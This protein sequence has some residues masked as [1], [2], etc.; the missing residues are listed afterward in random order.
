MDTRFDNNKP[1]KVGD[2][3]E[4]TIEGLGTKGDG[5]GKI[6]N[7]VVMVPNTKKGETVRVEITK[8]LRK[9]AFGKIEG[10]EDNKEE[11]N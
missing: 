5:F 2:I 10:S 6:E 1:I 11:E 4:L 3:I 7:F 8:V 9:M